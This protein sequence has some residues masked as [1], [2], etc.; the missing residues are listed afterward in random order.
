MASLS[1]EGR[2]QISEKHVLELSRIG[3]KG[4]ISHG[5]LQLELSPDQMEMK[6]KSTE[7][8]EIY[9]QNVHRKSFLKQTFRLNCLTY[10]LGIGRICRVTR[11]VLKYK[12]KT[13]K[14]H[15]NDITLV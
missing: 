15:P 1:G 6:Q 11:S 13:F 14:G 2:L 8:S 9:Q 4:S 5:L 7:M 10:S 12:I 3:V